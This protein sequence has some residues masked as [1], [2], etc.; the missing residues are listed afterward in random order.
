MKMTLKDKIEMKVAI[1][2]ISTLVKLLASAKGVK[3]EDISD[4]AKDTE[5][6]IFALAD[7]CS[8]KQE[9]VKNLRT[10]REL[11]RLLTTLKGVKHTQLIVGK[12]AK[13]IEERTANED[14]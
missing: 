7:S 10:L 2:C 14:R 1:K 11:P 5:D 4:F 6:L 13:S 12:A 3:D 9:F 8:T